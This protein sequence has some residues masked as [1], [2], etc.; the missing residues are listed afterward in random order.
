[1]KQAL[2]DLAHFVRHQK[3][4]V[5]GL[6]NAKVIILGCS[7]AGSIVAYFRKDYPELI[8]GGWSSCAGL[9]YR[10]DYSGL[11]YTVVQLL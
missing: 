11:V 6:A 5:P 2:A 3:T 10:L 8:D 9:Y 4:S 7:Y 1:M